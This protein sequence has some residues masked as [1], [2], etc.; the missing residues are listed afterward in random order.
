MIAYQLKS[1]LYLYWRRFFS[2]HE[3]H[4]MQLC[5]RKAADQLATNAL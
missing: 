4:K 1:Q 3:M 5:I 2:A